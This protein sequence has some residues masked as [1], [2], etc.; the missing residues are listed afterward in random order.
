MQDSLVSLFLSLLLVSSKRSVTQAGE[1]GVQGNQTGL[2]L[3]WPEFNFVSAFR[4]LEPLAKVNQKKMRN[5]SG[6]KVSAQNKG[7]KT[8]ANEL[9]GKR[10]TGIQEQ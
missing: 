8:E 3:A 1:R 10:R 2:S 9:R 4:P 6:V 7:V 5:K